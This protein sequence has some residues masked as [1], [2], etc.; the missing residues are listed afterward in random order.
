MSLNL[1]AVHERHSGPSPGSGHAHQGGAGLCL[2]RAPAMLQLT[3]CRSSPSVASSCAATTSLS[4]KPPPPLS[5]TKS[6][7]MPCPSCRSAT[8]PL[9]YRAR[10]LHAVARVMG[11]CGT[12]CD[13]KMRL[14]GSKDR[15]SWLQVTASQ[16][17]DVRRAHGWRARLDQIAG[18][19]AQTMQKMFIVAKSTAT[20]AYQRLGEVASIC[21]RERVTQHNAASS[22]SVF[23]FFQPLTGCDIV[24]SDSLLSVLRDAA[25]F[26]I[27]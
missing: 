26:F 12:N 17:C 21:H 1:L 20:A 24:P 10:A 23:G 11:N 3:R 6:K 27:R 18:K 9:A 22:K 5:A 15:S 13:S 8:R 14:N 19:A 16:L 4:F 2:A 25:A 7:T